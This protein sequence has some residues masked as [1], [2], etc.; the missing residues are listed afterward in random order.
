MTSKNDFDLLQRFVFESCDIRGEIVS[1]HNSFLEAS[2][3]QN[4]V[5]LERQLLGEFLAAT[6]LLGDS[7]KF[8]GVLTLQARG[9]GII[10]LVM[11]DITNDK[12]IRGI[13]KRH[14]DADFRHSTARLSELLGNA[15][16]SL[17]IDPDKGERYQGIVPAE[18]DSIASCLNTYFAQS[19]QLP[20]Y[21]LT[22]SQDNSCGGLFLQA[23]PSKVIQDPELA[24]D[25]WQTAVH[26]AST[27]KAEELFSLSHETLLYRL[28]HELE[29]KVFPPA[30][31]QFKC[32]CDEQRSSNAIA[33]LGKEDAFALLEEQGVIEI[34]C[35]FCGR[36]Y[37]FDNSALQTLFAAS[38]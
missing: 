13:V 22:F 9:D 28:F 20:S 3:H 26:L 1:L 17:T 19:E 14:V 5:P 34:N 12:Q 2:A 33:A 38:H 15:V 24:R 6:A 27:L 37:L 18:G 8:K 29:C 21:F 32:S 23:L 25:K 36:Q 11:A 7:L 30:P 4:L 35:E 16:L 31:V 10:P